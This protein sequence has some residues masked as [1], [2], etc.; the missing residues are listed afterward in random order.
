MKIGFAKVDITP[1]VGV[2]LA[3]FGAFINRYA[4]LIR[5][6]IWARAMAVE[7][8]GKTLVVVSCDLL[9]VQK[10]ITQKARK[11]IH[12][13]TGIS[14][15]AIM[16]HCTHTHSAP[17]VAGYLGWGAPDEPYL[18]ILP[19]RIARACIQSWKNR[20][21]AE[22]SYSTAKC[23]QI[24]TNREYDNWGPPIEDALSDNW[25]PAKPEL[26]DTI[27][28]VLKAESHGKT[29]GFA[30]Y[31]GC[32][33]VVCCDH[34][35]QIHGDYCG[36]ATNMLERE[37]PGSIGLFLQG[38]EGDVNSCVVG[39]PEQESLL[40]LDI[41]AAR[42]ANAVRTGL[43]TAQTMPVEALDAKTVAVAFSRKDFSLEKLLSMR[44]EKESVLDA[45]AASDSDPKVRMATV[46]LL[47]LR[48]I[49]AALEKGL[50]VA[51]PTELQM[52]RIGPVG[53]FGTPFEVFQA[54][55]NEFCSKSRTKTPL[56]MSQTNDTLSYA[57]DR[58][59][60][61]RGGYAADVVPL[62]LG[63]LPFARIHDELVANLLALERAG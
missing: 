21:E 47:A 36:V 3:G 6:R 46:Y 17:N 16:V 15:Q 38:A 10:T 35:R 19:A 4:T 12:A 49:I 1:R 37:M 40:A 22:F 58:T 59:A 8:A 25:H 2:E 41:I 44:A 50:P 32:H 53:L 20:Q 51:P 55:K 48:K 63:T 61:A 43:R 28:H 54:V 39:K 31:F 18:E 56:V 24:G 34:N 9:G 52:L 45:P 60:A 62:I 13:E 42:Y 11:I 33:P 23:D 26:T 14:P 5:D 29:I 27:C 7:H 30:S 57:P